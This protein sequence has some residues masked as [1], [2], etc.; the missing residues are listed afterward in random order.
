M[1]TN[2]TSMC[3]LLVCLPDVNV[4]GVDVN[5]ERSRNSVTARADRPA[6]AGWAR[7]VHRHSVDAVE[8]TDLRCFGRRGPDWS[9]SSSVGAA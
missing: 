7:L 9:G 4:V 3:K 2:P 5:S 1:E 6:C 8:L